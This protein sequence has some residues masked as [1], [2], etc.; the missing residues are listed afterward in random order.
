L[1]AE[2]ADT[3]EHERYHR[4]DGG[5]YV[6]LKRIQLLNITGLRNTEADGEGVRELFGRRYISQNIIK[7]VSFLALLISS[8]V[9]VVLAAIPEYLHHCLVVLQEVVY[10]IF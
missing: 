5:D 6:R 8:E 9:V 2:V 7:P 3:V 4:V 1:E 10:E